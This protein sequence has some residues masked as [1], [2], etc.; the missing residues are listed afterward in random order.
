MLPSNARSS[1]HGSDPNSKMTLLF[2]MVRYQSLLGSKSPTFIPPIFYCNWSRDDRNL[3]TSHFDERHSVEV[4]CPPNGNGF[5]LS[6]KIQIEDAGPSELLKIKQ[7]IHGIH[8]F[9]FRDSICNIDF[10]L[11]VYCSRSD[12]KSSFLKGLALTKPD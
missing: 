8:V 3:G 4:K 6:T 1:L 7:F 10:I 9:I 5:I 2:K 12:H 11:F